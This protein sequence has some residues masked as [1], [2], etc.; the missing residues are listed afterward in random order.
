MK[1][2]LLTKAS[3]HGFLRFT[4]LEG[5]TAEVGG[6]WARG[7]RTYKSFSEV[8]SYRIRLAYNNS[9]SIETPSNRYIPDG[10]MIDETR[11]V[12]E[13]WTVR[14][15]VNFNREFGKHR[16]SALAGN[17]VRRLLT[18]TINMQAVWATPPRP[19]RLLR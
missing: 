13:S 1:T 7:N 19:V 9:T 6:N 3:R 8:D 2:I 17:E 18:T 5:L 10:D 11:Y 16:V 4:I 15:Q 12:N 14:T